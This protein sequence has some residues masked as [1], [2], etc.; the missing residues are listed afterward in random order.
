MLKLYNKQANYMKNLHKNQP[1]CPPIAQFLRTVGGWLIAH[2]D[3]IEYWLVFIRDFIMLIAMLVM[4]YGLLLI[5]GA[6]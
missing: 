1:P 4:C 6:M 5:G 2:A 3:M